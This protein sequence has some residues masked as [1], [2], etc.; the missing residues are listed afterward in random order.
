MATKSVDPRLRIAPPYIG[1]VP[2]TVNLLK[3]APKLPPGS[4]NTAGKASGSGTGSSAASGGG[5][6]AT[7]SGRA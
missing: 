4:D 2:G 3:S 5:D 1:W 6:W 7:I